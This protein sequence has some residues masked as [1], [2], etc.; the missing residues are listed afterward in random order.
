MVEKAV[1]WG[2]LLELDHPETDSYIFSKKLH[3]KQISYTFLKNFC[4]TYSMDQLLVDMI[5]IFFTQLVFL[6]SC[7]LQ[8]LFLYSFFRR[9]LY[10][11]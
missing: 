11:L 5:A 9:F 3:P 1:N 7:I 2:S 6:N 10:H 4:Y 8:D